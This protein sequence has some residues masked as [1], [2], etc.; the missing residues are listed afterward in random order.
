MGC[1][2]RNTTEHGAGF[3]LF[4]DAERAEDVV[5]AL[6]AFVP[7]H[8]GI[9][10]KVRL[11]DAGAEATS[12]RCLRL[13]AAGAS[14]IA[15][16]ARRAREKA[17]DPARWSEVSRVVHELR[18]KAQVLV[19]GDAL[20]G[21]SAEELRK[22][23]GCASVLVGRGAL[24]AGTQVF[25]DAGDAMASPIGDEYGADCATFALCRRYVQ[26]A[27]DVENATSNTAFVLQWMLHARMRERRASAALWPTTTAAAD[28]NEP[29]LRMCDKL[30]AA[31]SLAAVADAVDE[32]SYYQRQPRHEPL[33]DARRY[34][35][36]YFD[37][38]HQ[39]SDW[40]GVL[41][42]REIALARVV[43]YTPEP[44]SERMH[45]SAAAATATDTDPDAP[46]R[47]KKRKS[48]GVRLSKS[49]REA[50]REARQFNSP[51]AP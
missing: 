48:R 29:L 1:A 24:L 32:G 12:A 43:H 11:C 30:R 17:R 20:D 9:S 18:G 25:S 33:P 8:I 22:A 3:A 36:N 21:A 40:A 13:V 28:A 2:K 49:E 16:H 44:A 37:L 38:L 6:R 45:G 34:L 46:L 5:R 26:L 10:C 35:G 7:P 39:H 4:C 23:S 51:P 14:S 42:R 19:N 31:T 15:I 41:P 27:I 50:R 47:I